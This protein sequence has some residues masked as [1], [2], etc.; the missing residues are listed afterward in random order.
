MN[1][2]ILAE[3]SPDDMIEFFG[4]FIYLFP[5]SKFEQQ[6]QPMFCVSIVHKDFEGVKRKDS[7]PSEPTLFKLPN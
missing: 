1:H 5:L 3:N 4:V 2:F 7:S 6:K